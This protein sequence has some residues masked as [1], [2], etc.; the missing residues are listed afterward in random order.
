M[1]ALLIFL[2]LLQAEHEH[3]RL[4]VAIQDTVFQSGGHADSLLAAGLIRNHTTPARLLGRD[5][6]E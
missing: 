4:A 2:M 6:L 3:N 1:W 5:A